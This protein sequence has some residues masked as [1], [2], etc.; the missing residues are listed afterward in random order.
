MIYFTTEKSAGY[1]ARIF[2]HEAIYADQTNEVVGLH[3]LAK[4]LSVWKGADKKITLPA[5]DFTEAWRKIG[6]CGFQCYI[7]TGIELS[8]YEMEIEEL[9]VME[10]R[11]KARGLTNITPILCDIKQEW[12]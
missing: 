11:C 6:K 3:E 1:G 5:Q 7:E 10:K 12:H 2:L 4:Q 9:I 8:G